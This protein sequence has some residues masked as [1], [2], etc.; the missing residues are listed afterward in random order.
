M[1]SSGHLS[2]GHCIYVGKDMTIRDNFSKPQ[3]VREQKVLGNTDL[4]CL[5]VNLPSTTV[6]N[7]LCI[8]AF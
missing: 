7:T 6:R 3:G 1:F 5:T 2:S 8:R 4:G